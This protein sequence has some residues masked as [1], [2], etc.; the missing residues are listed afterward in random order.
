MHI[1]NIFSC[2]FSANFIGLTIVNLNF[3]HKGLRK[4]FEQNDK[5]GIQAAHAKRI[6]LILDLLDGALRPKDMDFPGSDFHILKG[7]LKEYYSVHVNGNWT[8][9]FRFVDGDAMDIDLVDY[10]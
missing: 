8:L 10:H 1:S 7:K 9:I 6:D 5:S 4:F 2:N 3:R